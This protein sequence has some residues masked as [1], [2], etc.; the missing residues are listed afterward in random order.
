MIISSSE[1]TEFFLFPKNC[2]KVST[3]TMTVDEEKKRYIFEIRLFVVCG[4]LMNER[5][6]SKIGTLRSMMETRIKSPQ[7]RCY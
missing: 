7:L 3:L 1:G 4:D 6:M 5:K 2:A